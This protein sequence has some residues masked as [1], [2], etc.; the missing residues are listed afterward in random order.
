MIF[1]NGTTVA[2]WTTRT[3]RQGQVLPD[4]P[5]RLAFSGCPSAAFTRRRVHADSPCGRPCYAAA[6]AAC[7]SLQVNVRLRGARRCH[8]T[9]GQPLRR[10][11][12]PAGS[13][14]AARN[15]AERAASAISHRAALLAAIT[16]CQTPGTTHTSEPAVTYRCAHSLQFFALENSDR[17]GA[18]L[19]KLK[20]ELQ[21]CAVGQCALCNHA[22]QA[23]LLC[24]ALQGRTLARVTCRSVLI[25][26]HSRQHLE[27]LGCL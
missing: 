10:R 20:R 2:V 5:Q 14:A 16:E 6:T 7:L 12:A 8:A 26:R 17:E 23:V 15:R 19:R 11:G 3:N 22:C 1:N 21:L 18:M 24:D 27:Q 9:C 4:G 13:P 25:L